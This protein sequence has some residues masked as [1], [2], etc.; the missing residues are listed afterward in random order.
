MGHRTLLITLTAVAWVG[1]CTTTGSATT[2][3]SE[4]LRS[5]GWK[6]GA[7]VMSIPNFRIDGFKALDD[8]HLVIYSGVNRR[9]LVSFGA[10]CSGLLFAQR[11]AYSAPGGSLGRLDRLTVLGQG[12]RIDCVIDSI[13]PLE[14]IAG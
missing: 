8:S 12:I 6:P 1:A 4:Q 9:H 3:W 7:T 2:D 10:P 13:Q 5:D 11:L 14:K